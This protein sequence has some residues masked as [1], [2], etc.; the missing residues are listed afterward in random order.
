MPR[1]VLAP[2]SGGDMTSR[3]AEVDIGKCYELDGVNMVLGRVSLTQLH[4]KRFVASRTHLSIEVG[5]KQF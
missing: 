1:G 3:S 2:M 5:F 4:L